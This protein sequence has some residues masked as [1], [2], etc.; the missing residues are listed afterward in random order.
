MGTHNLARIWRLSKRIKSAIKQ[1]IALLT[2]LSSTAA[3]KT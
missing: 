2:Y 1:L 3:F